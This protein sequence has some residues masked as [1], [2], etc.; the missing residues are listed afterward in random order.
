MGDLEQCKTKDLETMEEPAGASVESMLITTDS[1]EEFTQ[2]LSASLEDDATLANRLKTKAS[3]QEIQETIESPRL[4]GAATNQNAINNGPSTSNDSLTNKSARELLALS[5]TGFESDHEP[6]YSGESNGSNGGDDYLHD[7]DWLNQREHV[8]VISS[9]GKPIYSLHGN[10]DKLATL[11][12]VMQ[13][14]VSVVHASQDTIMSIH[15][16]GIKFVFLVKGPLILVAASRRHISVQQ[17][18]LQLT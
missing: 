6:F 13:A 2:E 3:I 11:C 9:A 7:T 12:G 4:Q 18:H 17:I 16:A 10:E 5:E 8:F 1:F 15:A 14:L